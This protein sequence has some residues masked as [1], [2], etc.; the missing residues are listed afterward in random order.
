MLTIAVSGLN[1]YLSLAPKEL[2]DNDT[3]PHCGKGIPFWMQK[4]RHMIS[5]QYSNCVLYWMTL[6]FTFLIEHY[7]N[8]GYFTL[9]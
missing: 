5:D 6:L 2:I 8:S 7:N 4:N 1:K 3:K 9:Y